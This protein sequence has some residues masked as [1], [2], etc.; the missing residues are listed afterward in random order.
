M[1]KHICFFLCVVLAFSILPLAEADSLPRENG[2]DT[3]GFLASLNDWI[4]GTDWGILSGSV[5]PEGRMLKFILSKQSLDALTLQDEKDIREAMLDMLSLYLPSHEAAG[6]F[7]ILYQAGDAALM[8]AEQ[9]PDTEKDA[10]QEQMGAAKAN[11]VFIHHSVGENWLRQGLAR[12]LNDHGYHVADITYGWREYG[13]Y[14]DTRD[15]PGWFTDGVMALVYR[16]LGTMSAENS[17]EPAKG[18]NTVILFKSCFPNSDTGSSI[19]DEKAVYNSLLP[20]FRSR[21]DKLFILATPPPMI[22]ISSPG[23]TRQLCRWLTDRQG[24]WLASLETGNVFVFDLYNV[25]THPDAH[26][27]MVDGQEVHTT[28]PHADT[29]YYDSDGDDH[30]NEQGSQKAA[31]EFILLLDHWAAQHSTGSG[32]ASQLFEP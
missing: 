11:L 3:E 19:D 5:D 2:M 6:M 24:G 4:L 23:L 27:Q 20:Y 22:R 9:E 25:L 18:E 17:L 28:V 21:P 32:D 14:T 15:W 10:P 7:S 13:D 16:E 1:R 12:M 29:L 8:E 30:P 26:H 31:E